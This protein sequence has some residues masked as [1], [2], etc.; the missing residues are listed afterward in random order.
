MKYDKIETPQVRRNSFVPQ[1]IRPMLTK[2][3]KP[4]CEKCG[5]KLYNTPWRIKTIKNKCFVC[6]L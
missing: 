2:D 6:G 1:E 5:K 3:L 4:N